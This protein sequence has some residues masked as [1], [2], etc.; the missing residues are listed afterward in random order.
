MEDY[1]EQEEKD[2]ELA[3]RLQAE[4]DQR[5]HTPMNR[6]QETAPQAPSNRNDENNTNTSTVRMTGIGTFARVDN[7]AN[8]IDRNSTRE[9][10]RQMGIDSRDI[11][12]DDDEEFARKTEQEF[13]D[14]ALAM[15]L[16]RKE[17]LHR[18]VAPLRGASCRGRGVAP[19][20]SHTSGA[21]P[22][23]NRRCYNSKGCCSAGVM[24]IIVGGAAICIVLFGSNIWEGFGGDADD[25]PPFFQDNWPESGGTGEFSSWRNK[26]KGLELL[27]QNSLTSDWDTYFVEAVKDWNEAPALSLIT[28]NIDVDPDCT[29]VTGIMKV[30]NDAYG[31]TGWTGLNEVYFTGGNSK[32]SAS[33]AKMNESYLNGKSQA[34]KQY[35][36]CHEIG[37][38]FGLPHRDE[39]ANN[40]DL[41]S[42]LDYTHRYKNNMRPDNIVDFDNLLNLYG[43]IQA[44]RLGSGSVGDVD[45]DVDKHPQPREAISNIS[46]K[47]WSYREGRMLMQTKHY[48]VY[49]N[50]LGDGD[51]VVTTVLLSQSN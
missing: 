8:N 24:A 21:A 45:V 16:Q 1:Y 12:I 51:S 27:I 36:M 6:Q 15:E 23:R 19:V 7:Y 43:E 18:N 39:N 50:D 33:V 20:P 44:R 37:H 26:S 30:C 46:K 17:Q 28:E 22:S 3:R 29:S 42:C 47:Q 34:E 49:E 25:L 2:A 48:E 41:G 38:G 4:E 35:V 9:L 40:P 32:I 31:F 5:A 13:R 14:E 11:D 10:F